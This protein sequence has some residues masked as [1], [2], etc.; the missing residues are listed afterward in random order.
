MENNLLFREKIL[1]ASEI[2]AYN[3]LHELKLDNIMIPHTLQGNKL[4]M[5]KGVHPSRLELDFVQLYQNIL[6]KLYAVQSPNFTPGIYSFFDT[7]ICNNNTTTGESL[8]LDYVVMEQQNIF[9]N[10]GKY[11]KPI[12]IRT[13]SE[14]IN[15]FFKWCKRNR[16]SFIPEY[17]LLH[18][19]LFIG[20][21]LFYHNAYKLIDL[22]FLRFGPKELEIAFLLCWD[23]I[24]NPML[25][26]YS[27]YVISKNIDALVAAKIIKETDVLSIVNGFMPLIVSLASIA[28]SANL[29]TDSNVIL[30]GCNS[31]W[32]DCLVR[33]IQEV[34]V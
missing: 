24:S 11:I 10:C 22:E 13:Y 27:H 1:S 9:R 5:A 2:H 3:L 12:V 28:A 21:I 34:P 19:D 4:K 32:N 30:D 14:S 31:L 20:N 29:Y 8:Y 26:L 6:C 25:K 33:K 15:Q 18:G 23:F 7:S 17:V 16:N